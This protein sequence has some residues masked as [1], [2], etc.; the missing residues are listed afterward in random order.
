MF[1]SFIHF[2]GGIGMYKW[3]LFLMF[4]SIYF[5]LRD[6]HKSLV[7]IRTHSLTTIR[8]LTPVEKPY[9]DWSVEET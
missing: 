7:T 5:K 3:I 8:L 4:I 9:E 6:I 1:E 2:L